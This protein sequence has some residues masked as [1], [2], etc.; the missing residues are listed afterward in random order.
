M[1]NT[2]L[3]MKMLGFLITVFCSPIF[4]TA[5]ITE[6]FSDGNLSLN[7]V[8]IGNIENFNTNDSFQLQL[9]AEGAGSSFLSTINQF[10]QNCEWQFWI[11]LGFSPSANNN[12]RVYLL[13]DKSDLSDTN[14]NG[15]FLQFGEA[16]SND[17][18]ELFRQ[19]G[20]EINSICRSSEA[21]VS[22]SFELRVKITRS[23][24]GF[25]ELFVDQ[26]GGRLFAFEAS[27]SD[28]EIQSSGY[29][30]FFCKYTS[31]NS[32]NFYF[33]DVY[34]GEPIIDVSPPE[35]W[36]LEIIQAN[37]LEIL[38]SEPLNPESIQTLE[39][40][41]VDQG[42]GN[43]V[44]VQ[45]DESLQKIDLIF[46]SSFEENQNYQLS[47][48]NIQD[49]YEN[50]M[51]AT[52]IGFT[53][54]VAQRNDLVINEILFD[55][56]VGC[57]E[58]VEVYN[59]SNKVLNFKHI[60]F[61][62]IKFDFPNPPDTT[63]CRISDTSIYIQPTDYWVLSSSPEDVKKCYFTEAEDHFIKVSN[64]PDFINQ[65]GFLFLVSDSGVIINEASYQEKMHHSSLNF[66]DGVALEKINFE[67]DGLSKNSWQSATKD[68]G[69]GT[70]AYQNSQFLNT[71]TST[72]KI[73]IT[74]E[75][76]SPDQDGVDDL[77]SISLNFDEGGNSI[78]IFVFN[79][80][81]QQIRYLVKNELAG[82][83]AQYFWNGLDEENNLLPAGVYIIYVEV[84][85]IDGNS[86]H[87]KET[88]V[89]A[90]KFN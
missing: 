48:Q 4:C 18:I 74:P 23:E 84:F 59:R 38:F 42:I 29:F 66:T 33:D 11:K 53:Y 27:G 51:E 14:L 45:S 12:C 17:A 41:S 49:F 13:A 62:R 21:L 73:K 86:D 8:W 39:N 7:P 67:A 60:D 70:P 89:L 88:T 79:S 78:N 46:S 3:H 9:Y 1:A 43:P 25:W 56:L 54:F 71:D 24:Y 15:Y 40:F 31:S 81:G 75:V 90:R 26:N 61:G 32:Q 37:H 76:F 57:E 63:L 58:Y 47:L 6:N 85:N 72:E 5:Q 80:D 68:V 64:L 30:G 19:N 16:G 36:S 20:N 52:S 34:V 82:T 55:P 83:N 35:L 22:S 10:Q 69:F 44:L 50:T 65:E 2:K 28:Q 77:L 87:Y